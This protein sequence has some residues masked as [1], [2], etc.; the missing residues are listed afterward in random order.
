VFGSHSELRI[1]EISG[2]ERR[3]AAFAEIHPQILCLGTLSRSKR[4]VWRGGGRST[5]LPGTD[6]RCY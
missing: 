4:W 6:T 1:E 5:H 3:A 2:R